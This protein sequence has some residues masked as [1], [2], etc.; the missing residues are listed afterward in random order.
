MAS[1][2][3][4]RATAFEPLERNL[5]YLRRHMTINQMQNCIIVEA[6]VS[7]TEGELRFSAAPWEFSIT[8]GVPTES[9]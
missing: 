6:A 8:K 4:S 3:E 1:P 2:T 7:N 5:R 9:Q